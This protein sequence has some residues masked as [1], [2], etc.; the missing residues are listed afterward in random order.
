MGFARVFS[1]YWKCL[2]VFLEKEHENLWEVRCGPGICPRGGRGEAASFGGIPLCLSRARALILLFF[3]SLF[4]RLESIVAEQFIK[5]IGRKTLSIWEKFPVYLGGKPRLS[6]RNSPLKMGEN[7]LLV[8]QL[9]QSK[10]LSLVIV[11]NGRKSPSNYAHMGEI[12]RHVRI[13]RAID[14]FSQLNNKLKTARLSARTLTAGPNH[15]HDH[16]RV[17]SWLENN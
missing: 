17:L 15:K 7:I 16:W 5:A 3:F 2:F 10:L 9:K 1:L 4:G 6:G 11:V 12:P 13:G 8:S 14:Y